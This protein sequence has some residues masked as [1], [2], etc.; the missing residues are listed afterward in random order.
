[1]ML[2]R[3][4]DH[5]KTKQIIARGL[6]TGRYGMKDYE[7]PID[8]VIED[9]SNKSG[10]I[11]IREEFGREEPPV[12]VDVAFDIGCRPRDVRNFLT[13]KLGQEIKKGGMLAKKGEA[14]A[15]FT[16]CCYAPV[17]GIVESVD[18]Q[19]GIVT[20]SRPFKEVVVKAYIKGTVVEKIEGRGVVVETP[21]ARLTGIFGLGGERHGVIRVL[22]ERHDQPL[23]PDLIDDSCKGQIVVGG[24][25]ATDEALAKAVQVGCAGVIA[26]TAH[27]LNLVK[28]LGVKLGV[29][30][31]G[32]EDVDITVILM[33]GFGSLA[34]REQAFRALQALDGREASI[35]GATQVRAGAIR[36]EIIVPFPEHAGEGEAA[37][38]AD[39]DFHVGQRVRL[40]NEPYFGL[41]G[42]IREMPREDMVVE[43][44][45]RV[46]VASVDVGDRVVVVPRKNMEPF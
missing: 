24:A 39:E 4:G 32:T 15:F 6:T 31:T 2:V 42:T 19:T 43:T 21:A 12:K 22:T 16:K 26:G 44:E 37:A 36:P 11:V 9:I 38:Q 29:G 45:A 14:S 27:Y 7:A 28:S 25:Q 10:R 8:G 17:S 3:V 30:I 20:I 34:M 33:E 40:I 1:C 41:V 18:D 35:N 13:V 5:V 46:P 23:T